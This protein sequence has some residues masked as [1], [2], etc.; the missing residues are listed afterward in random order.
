MRYASCPTAGVVAPVA[1][2]W[3]SARGRRQGDQKPDIDSHVLVVAA[4]EGVAVAGLDEPA[5][6]RRDPEHEVE[7]GDR[8]ERTGGRPL[9]PGADHELDVLRQ[10]KRLFENQVG[11][12][13]RTVFAVQ[14]TDTGL[15]LQPMLDRRHLDRDARAEAGFGILDTPFADRAKL[16]NRTAMVVVRFL[17]GEHLPGSRYEADNQQGWHRI[18]QLHHPPLRCRPNLPPRLCTGGKLP[19]DYKKDTKRAPSRNGGSSDGSADH[20]R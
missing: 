1:V 7:H 14:G 13:F 11:F 2:V 5:I 18:A 12:P 20:T 16:E 10:L 19:P 17:T 6:I 8:A 9:R 3:T 15:D 4:G